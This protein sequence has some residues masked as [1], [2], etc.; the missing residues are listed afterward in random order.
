MPLI[1]AVDIAHKA[2]D[3]VIVGGGT[4]GLVLATRLTEDTNASVL[5]LE[6]GPAN[7]NDPLLLRMGSYG[8]HFNQEKYDW[9]FLT[10]PQ[11]HCNNRQIPW[12]R[13]KTLGGS[14][15]INFLAWVKP[16]K[17]EINDFE[18]LG[19]PGWNWKNFEKYCAKAEG[20]VKPSAEEIEKHGLHSVGE[21]KMG[22]DGPIKLAIPSRAS[23]A[24]LDAIKVMKSAGIPEAQAPQNGD[25]RGLYIYPISVDPKTFKRSYAANAYW[26][27]NQHRPNLSCIVSATA[28]KVIFEE[29]STPLKATGVEFIVN[30]GGEAT[31]HVA[32]AGKEVILCAGAI[33]TP[34]LLELSGIGSPSILSRYGI[35]TK[36]D[37]PE[38]GENV[39]EHNTANVTFELK[40]DVPYETFDV[41]RYPKRAAEELALHSQGQG[42]FTYGSLGYTFAPLTW[43]SPRAREIHEAQI[44]RVNEF[45]ATPSRSGEKSRLTEGL[46]AQFEIMKERLGPERLG[47]GCEMMHAAMFRSFPNPPEPG[48]KYFSYNSCMHHQWSRGSIHIAS[49]DPFASPVIDPHAFE[50]DIDLQ[51]FIETVKFV[52]TLRHISPWKELVVREVNPGPDVQTDAQIGDYVKSY[53][54]TTFHTAGT[55]S[56]LPREKGG[57]VDPQ[58]KVYGTSNLRVVDMSIVPLLFAAHVQ[59]VLYAIAEQAADIIKGE[60]VA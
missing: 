21:W 45:T 32:T 41:L 6:A 23:G 55:A 24:D 50:E 37:M 13:G 46:K 60:F 58:L 2:F 27:P 33:K 34:Q 59:S 5:V 26:I 8:A 16:P 20:F 51:T 11:K 15:A 43:L 49:T 56:M 44:S 12:P 31:V 3:Y 25:P 29:G 7:E 53:M 9:S 47:P 28:H 39:Q 10:V 52:R 42:L 1:T 14:S 22:E 17:E 36:I 38:V 48:K 18:R 30:S 54:S 4:A 19:N 35:K 40:D 57:V